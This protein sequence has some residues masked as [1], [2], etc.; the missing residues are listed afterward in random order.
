LLPPNVSLV[1][2][3]T[4]AA[5]ERKTIQ[6][7]RDSVGQFKAPRYTD[8]ETIL[9]IKSLAADGVSQGDGET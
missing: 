3:G 7:R 4:Y 8:M 6:E 1:P 9:L 5:L 2:Y